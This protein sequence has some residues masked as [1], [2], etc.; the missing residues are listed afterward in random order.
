MDQGILRIQTSK[1]VRPQARVGIERT[2]AAKLLK[3]KEISCGGGD[4]G[5][6]TLGTVPRTT[7]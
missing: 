1:A 5:I 7:L 2:L 3:N 4:G 6:R